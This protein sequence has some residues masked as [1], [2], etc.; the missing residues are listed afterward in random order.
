M[1][2]V[3][4]ERST[5]WSIGSDHS[6]SPKGAS[7]AS[8][9]RG[10][11][12]GSARRLPAPAETVSVTGSGDG[13]AHGQYDVEIATRSRCPGGIACAMASSLTVTV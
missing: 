5:S 7:A 11:R 6:G 3:G 10:A 1:R 13:H 12:T 8:L 2:L 4:S 9:S